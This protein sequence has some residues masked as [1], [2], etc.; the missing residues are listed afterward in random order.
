MNLKVPILNNLLRRTYKNYPYCRK[1][2]I[3]YPV[4]TVGPSITFYVDQP[5]YG[6]HGNLVGYDSEK[7]Y[8]FMCKDCWDKSTVQERIRINSEAFIK[9][10]GAWEFNRCRITMLKSIISRSG[11]SYRTFERKEKLEKINKNR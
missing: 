4:L 10:F 7:S 5:T 9:R 11:Q 1:C 6:C 8:S 2:N 3:P